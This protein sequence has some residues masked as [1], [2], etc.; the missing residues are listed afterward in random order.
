MTSIETSADSASS[1]VLE[2]SRRFWAATESSDVEAMRAIAA[3][4]CRFVHIGITC[5]L[6]RE[7][8]FYEDGVF[9]PTSVDFH[10]QDVTVHGPT[11]VV[12]SDV[13]YSLTWQIGRA[14]CR[15]RV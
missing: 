8:R 11:A 3:P 1:G 10:G 12:I 13:D 14:S 9:Q 6:D 4:E 2:T 7:I 5:D 15:E